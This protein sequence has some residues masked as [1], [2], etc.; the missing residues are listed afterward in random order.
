MYIE[1][2]TYNPDENILPFDFFYIDCELRCG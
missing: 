1:Y 2:T